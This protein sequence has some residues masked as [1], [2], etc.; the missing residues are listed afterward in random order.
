MAEG[1]MKEY[2]DTDYGDYR[3]IEDTHCWQDDFDLTQEEKDYIVDRH[4]EYLE[5]AAERCG[6]DTSEWDLHDW[7]AFEE[8]IS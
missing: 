4:W 7:W 8:Y 2:R 3:D 6:L 5:D 1:S